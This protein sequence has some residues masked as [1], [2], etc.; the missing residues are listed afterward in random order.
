[1]IDVVFVIV[2][3]VA[4]LAISLYAIWLLVFRTKRGESKSLS[5]GEWLKHT[6]EALWG[7]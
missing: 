1:M 3:I 7:L 6:F 4:A 2:E 5:F